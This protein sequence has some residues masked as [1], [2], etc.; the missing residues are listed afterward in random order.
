M[1]H[2]FAEPDG[3]GAQSVTVVDATSRGVAKL[4][5]SCQQVVYVLAD[6]DL[7]QFTV[8]RPGCMRAYWSTLT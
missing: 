1:V 7:W 6:G 3:I 8:I 2:G 5:R 4:R